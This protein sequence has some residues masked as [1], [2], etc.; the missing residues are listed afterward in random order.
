MIQASKPHL[1]TACSQ[2][3][4]AVQTRV[5]VKYFQPHRRTHRQTDRLTMYWWAEMP[6]QRSGTEQFVYL[7]FAQGPVE[8]SLCC[9]HLLLK[10]LPLFQTLCFHPETQVQSCQLVVTSK[11]I[12]RSISH[13]KAWPLMYALAPRPR[14]S[15]RWIAQFLPGAQNCMQVSGAWHAFHI[16]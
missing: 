4:M 9:C 8:S 15:M 11:H 3:D 7:R 13:S 16:M 6:T 12:V 2:C 1:Q 5:S 14:H 10:L